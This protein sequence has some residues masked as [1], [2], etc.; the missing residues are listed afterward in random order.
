MH[1][2]YATTGGR[3]RERESQPV[4]TYLRLLYLSLAGKEMSNAEALVGSREKDI[5]VTTALP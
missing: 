5:C 1:V 2:T 4:R 3:E